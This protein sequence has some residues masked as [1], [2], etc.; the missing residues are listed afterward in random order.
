MCGQR[1]GYRLE[2]ID[3]RK[4]KA[5]RAAAGSGGSSGR[6]AQD[7]VYQEDFSYTPPRNCATIEQWK[8]EDKPLIEQELKKQNNL[9][10][11]LHQQ[12]RLSNSGIRDELCCLSL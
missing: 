12:V 7:F 5:P 4:R 1:Q 8:C 9:L 2:E 11:H 6:I 3:S 10:N